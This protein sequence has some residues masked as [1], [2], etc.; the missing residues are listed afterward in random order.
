MTRVVD[1]RAYAKQYFVRA[2]EADSEELRRA[3]LEM[4][5]LLDGGRHADGEFKRWRS[6]AKTEVC[7]ERVLT[8]AAPV[9]V[10]VQDVIWN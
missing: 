3:S 2:Q 9:T 7:L 1:Y 6:R 8:N 5:R 4:A 10:K